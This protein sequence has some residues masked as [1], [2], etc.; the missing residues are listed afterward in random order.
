MLHDITIVKQGVVS[1]LGNSQTFVGV[2]LTLEVLC[3]FLDTESN[4]INRLLSSINRK[5]IDQLKALEHVIEV[6]IVEFQNS[7]EYQKV[8][9]ICNGNSADDTEITSKAQALE[10]DTS[11]GIFSYQ[12]DISDSYEP[13][14]AIA[15]YREQVLSPVY[16]LCF[17][18]IIFLIDEITN[19]TGSVDSRLIFG[20]FVFTIL[21]SIYLLSIWATFIYHSRTAHA[22]SGDTNWWNI[23]DQKFGVVFLGIVK[24][25]ICGIIY[26]V[27][28]ICLPWDMMNAWG[29]TFFNIL[30]FSMPIVMLGIIRISCCKVKGYYS[31]LHTIG[32]LISIAAF[33]IMIAIIYQLIGTHHN[34]QYGLLTNIESLR[35]SIVVFLCL[36]GVICPFLLPYFRCS[37]E[38]KKKRKAIAVSDKEISAEIEAFPAKYERFCSAIGKSVIDGRSLT[39]RETTKSDKPSVCPELRSVS[40]E[41]ETESDSVGIE[42]DPISQSIEEKKTMDDYIQLYARLIPQPR[43]IEFCHSHGIDHRSF[44]KAWRSH[45]KE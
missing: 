11:L 34:I 18:L 30:S 17:G 39:N 12:S 19:L 22:V 37:Q 3:I 27:A 41:E 7:G 25:V 32:H 6:K 45:L 28:L 15:K 31:Y 23:L 1:L 38:F 2:I 10:Y 24:A 35:F 42:D 21:S 26:C 4:F 43:M 20:T 8:S 36:F 33:S 40:I 16:C 13:I 14:D 44:K 5:F 9:E 29:K